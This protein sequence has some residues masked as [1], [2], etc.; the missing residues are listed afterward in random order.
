MLWTKRKGPEPESPEYINCNKLY[1]TI[2]TLTISFASAELTFEIIVLNKK[3][4]GIRIYSSDAQQ[5]IPASHIVTPIYPISRH[6][7]TDDS[8]L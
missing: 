7:V 1:Y 8:I 4:F 2:R 5:E 6:F 3:Y